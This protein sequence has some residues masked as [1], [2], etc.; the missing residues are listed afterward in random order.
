VHGRTMSMKPALSEAQCCPTQSSATCA[1]NILRCVVPWDLYPYSQMS[2]SPASTTQHKADERRCIA[3]CPC[4]VQ[5]R[6]HAQPSSLELWTSRQQRC[7]PA[8]QHKRNVLGQESGCPGPSWQQGVRCSTSTSHGAGSDIMSFQ[9]STSQA[10]HS[11]SSL[12]RPAPTASAPIHSP[13]VHH[14]F[15]S[16]QQAHHHPTQH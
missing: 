8:D 4:N 10:Q 13:C 5:K 16:L 7:G 15:S 1:S 11:S 3:G 14:T 2:N 9:P 6:P 12:L